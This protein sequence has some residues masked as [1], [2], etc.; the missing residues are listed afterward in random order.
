M[1]S[2]GTDVELILSETTNPL[3]EGIASVVDV[4]SVV[5]VD[6]APPEPKGITLAITLEKGD[7]NENEDVKKEESLNEGIEA[8]STQDTSQ[9][10]VEP[11]EAKDVPEVPSEEDLSSVKLEDLKAR[12]GRVSDITKITR[13]LKDVKEKNKILDDF[14][15]AVCCK[16]STAFVVEVKN[17][18][19]TP[20][21]G[22]SVVR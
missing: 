22:L 12:R 10:K 7:G 17:H 8:I 4:A 21:V 3:D 15:I 9:K 11:E 16:T 5:L 13:L 6:E 14:K 1:A 20:I 18:P 19:S 2:N